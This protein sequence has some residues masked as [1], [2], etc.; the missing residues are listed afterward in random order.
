MMKL[1]M[2]SLL[3]SMQALMCL[4]CLDYRVFFGAVDSF[5]SALA[6]VKRSE[7]CFTRRHVLGFLL[8]S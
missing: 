3:A 1:S 5:P 4:S 6:F 7:T 2:N 8:P